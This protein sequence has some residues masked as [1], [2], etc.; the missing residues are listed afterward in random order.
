MLS[1]SLQDQ[2]ELPD[3]VTGMLQVFDLTVYAFLDPGAS[4]SYVNFYLGM[5]FDVIPKK[6][7]EPLSVSTL[8]DESIQA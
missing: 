6:I 4:L 3:V 2:E 1:N 5:N 7:S 8:V